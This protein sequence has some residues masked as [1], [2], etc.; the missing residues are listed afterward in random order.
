MKPSD[1]RLLTSSVDCCVPSSADNLFLDDHDVVVTDDLSASDNT[2]HGEGHRDNSWG[3][4]HD[5]NGHHKDHNIVDDRSSN[6]PGSGHND[7]HASDRNSDV[8]GCVSCVMSTGIVVLARRHLGL[9]EGRVKQRSRSVRRG[10][11]SFPTRE[12]RMRVC[13]PRDSRPGNRACVTN[14]ALTICIG[15]V[16][17]SSPLHLKHR[18]RERQ[19]G[20]FKSHAPQK[21]EEQKKESNNG[22]EE[23]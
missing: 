20:S 13:T 11:T 4:V 1:P 17:A 23:H 3:A 19:S 9:V 14:L 12:Q 2:F 8:Q 7:C 21:V 15:T 10:V 22:S 16:K 6:D 18:N 5:G